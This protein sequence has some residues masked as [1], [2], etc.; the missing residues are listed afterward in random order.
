MPP[1]PS[2]PLHSGTSNITRGHSCALCQQR[3]VKCDRQRPCSN[4][5][6]ARVECTTA[7]AQPRR[8]RKK[9]TE[10]DLTARLQ[11]YERLLKG[12][13]V[14]IDEDDSILAAEPAGSPEYEFKSGSAQDATR[15]R[16]VEMKPA[17]PIPGGSR[18]TEKYSEF[19]PLMHE[20]LT[21]SAT[22]GRTCETR[23][24]TRETPL[25]MY[26]QMMSCKSRLMLLL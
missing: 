19:C 26:L 7:P 3:K 1:S 9:L 22:F 16:V 21:L 5:T 13:G 8:R 23:F 2:H 25:R 14:K 20:V 11:K 6:K 15:P 12:H 17:F 4:C 10:T 18:Y 24:R